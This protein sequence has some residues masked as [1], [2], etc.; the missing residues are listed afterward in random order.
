MLG[1]IDQEDCPSA[2]KNT[3]IGLV[4]FCAWK[5]VPTD[6]YSSVGISEV[7]GCHLSDRGVLSEDHKNY[8]KGWCH[9]NSQPTFLTQ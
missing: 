7:T 1:S 6:I 3:G 5:C 2:G 8:F 9:M 4:P